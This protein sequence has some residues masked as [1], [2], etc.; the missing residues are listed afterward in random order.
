MNF[1][2]LLEPFTQ[3]QKISSFLYFQNYILEKIDKNEPFFIGRLSGNEPNLCG[4]ILSN[5]NLPNNLIYEMLN[6]AGIKFLNNN[7]IKQYVKTYNNACINSSILCIWSGSMYSQT[8]SYYDF[9]DK[10]KP[11]QPRICAQSLEPFYFMNNND[12]NFDKVFMNKKVLIITSHKQTTEKQLKENKNI[13]NKP[14]FHNTTEFYVYKPVQQ[15]G[16]NHDEHSWIYHF[17]NMKK[18]LTEINKTFN[19]NIALVSCGGFGMLVSDFIFTTLSKSAIYVGGGLQLY[20]GIIGNRWKSHPV[21]SKL[22]NDK[23]V[24]VLEEDKPAKLKLNP[25]LCENSCYW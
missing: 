5:N 16:G 25:R 17:E 4:R 13:F 6:G 2:N 14:I 8:K 22:I 19:F 9:L 21:I 11:D 15:N 23:W 3:E 10:I 20:F 12:Y 24:N 1:E 18:D 7:D